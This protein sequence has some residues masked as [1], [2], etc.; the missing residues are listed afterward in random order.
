MIDQIFEKP[1]ELNSLES[2]DYGLGAMSLTLPKLTEKNIISQINDANQITYFGTLGEPI[3]LKIFEG[4]PD[5]SKSKT[6]EKF[7][8]SEGYLYSS[9]LKQEREAG[10]YYLKLKDQL[11][12]EWIFKVEDNRILNCEVK[13]NLNFHSN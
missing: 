3:K 7:N 6:I 9:L 5:L 1:T 2:I 4:S 13:L 10:V 12:K 11:S 8:F